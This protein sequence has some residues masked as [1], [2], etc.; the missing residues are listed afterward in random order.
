MQIKRQELMTQ[1]SINDIDKK[2]RSLDDYGQ[3]SRNMLKDCQ[4]SLKDN[5][6]FMKQSLRESQQL[7]KENKDLIAVVKQEMINDNK[8]TR[9][10]NE[11][12]NKI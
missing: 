8:I 3:S 2:L 9:L 7:F 11:D 5:R 1:T 4:K 12:T 10:K 6:D